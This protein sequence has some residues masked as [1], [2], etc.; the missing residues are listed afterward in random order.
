M[1]ELRTSTPVNTLIG[2]QC[3]K[4]HTAEPVLRVVFRGPGSKIMLMVGL[5][6]HKLCRGIFTCVHIAYSNYIPTH[7]IIQH[8]TASYSIIQHH[9][10]SYLNA[11]KICLHHLLHIY[12]TRQTDSKISRQKWRSDRQTDRQMKRQVRMKVRWT[13]RYCR[14]GNFR[15]RIVRAFNFHCMGQWRN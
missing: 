15:V 4:H 2:Q 8:H 6:Q 11:D 13:D 7:S 10:V 5:T 9:T 14:L 1:E 3:S 12:S